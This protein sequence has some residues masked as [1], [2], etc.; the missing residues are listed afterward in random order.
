MVVSSMF[1]LAIYGVLSNEVDRFE[2]VQRFSFEDGLRLPMS[3]RTN[4]QLVIEAKNRILSMLVVI[5]VGIWI[6]SGGF[7]FFLSGKTLKPIEQMVD[8]QRRFV[9]DASHELRT[10]LT[11]LKTEIEVSLLNKSLTLDETR[12]LL[13]SNLEEI[14]KITNLS[15]SLLALNRYQSNKGNITL[16]N[17]DL[18]TLANE[19]CVKFKPLVNKRK[20]ELVNNVDKTLIQTN[21]ESLGKILSI[22]LDNAIKYSKTGGKVIIASKKNYRQV[23][24]S[25]TDFGE[26]IEKFDLPH[27]FDRFYRADSSR[28]KDKV[29]GFGLG[30]SIAK[31]I[32]DSLG[33][34]IDAQSKVGVGSK[35][36]IVLRV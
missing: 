6:T 1:S 10:P 16:Q 24:I 17:F 20:I 2:R 35:F 5:N 33:A 15:D 25:I 14:E 27:I 23:E 11:A 12:A 9:A 22:F 28:S 3:F 21:R 34:R 31:G 30:L 13:N 18:T 36:Q 29:G 4:P 26:G 8:E 32:A 19:L 7:A